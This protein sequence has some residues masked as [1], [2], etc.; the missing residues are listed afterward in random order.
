MD[1][2]LYI[3][4]DENMANW[5]LST[6]ESVIR[7]KHEKNSASSNSTDIICKHFINAVETKVCLSIV[8]IF[9]AILEIWMVLGL[10][11]WRR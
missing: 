10:P 2:L 1:I 11:R 3:L 5:D 9:N 4:L 7:E 6:L 8:I